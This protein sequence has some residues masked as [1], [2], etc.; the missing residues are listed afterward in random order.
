MIL[1]AAMRQRLHTQE[2]GE[3]P[4]AASVVELSEILNARQRYPWLMVDWIFNWTQMG[5]RQEKC[6]EIING[7]TNMVIKERRKEFEQ[8]SQ[9]LPTINE[10]PS[11][12]N[13][14]VIY[15]Y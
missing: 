15:L 10:D 2:V 11:E 13:G 3:S 5:R 8:E 4:Y 6:L 7:F 9:H 12:E 1:D 14:K